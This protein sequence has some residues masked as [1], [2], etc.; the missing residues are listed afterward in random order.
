MDRLGG[1]GDLSLGRTWKLRNELALAGFEILGV[2]AKPAEPQL[3]QLA[4]VWPTP[5]VETPLVRRANAALNFIWNR[6]RDLDAL[7]CSEAAKVLRGL[8]LG[9]GTNNPS[10][11]H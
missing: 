7:R 11:V 2:Q 1:L 4:S 5:P 9:L 10:K 3:L 8:A 6:D